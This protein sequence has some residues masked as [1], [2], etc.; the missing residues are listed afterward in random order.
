[1]QLFKLVARSL[2]ASGHREW[3]PGN[4][5]FFCLGDYNSAIASLQAPPAQRFC[6][7]VIDG[8]TPDELTGE[9]ATPPPGVGEAASRL[10]AVGCGAEPLG[11][12]SAYLIAPFAG[13]RLLPL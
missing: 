13:A 9:T 11:C 10:K 6:D 12:T 2:A 8:I 1:M 5:S 3:A 4:W 7:V